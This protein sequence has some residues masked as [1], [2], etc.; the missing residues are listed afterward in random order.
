MIF[1]PNSTRPATLLNARCGGFKRYAHSADP[2]LDAW[3]VGC[4]DGLDGLDGLEALHGL[5]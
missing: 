5:D 4:L 3:M 1:V 2:R